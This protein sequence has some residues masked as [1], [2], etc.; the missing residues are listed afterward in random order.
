MD[1]LE[2]RYGTNAFDCIASHLDCLPA[3]ASTVAFCARFSAPCSAAW[4]V[5]F[6]LIAAR[7]STVE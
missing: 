3:S 5:P 4:L 6:T 7:A 1:G 2:R